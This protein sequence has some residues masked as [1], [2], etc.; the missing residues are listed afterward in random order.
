M[1]STGIY[2]KNLTGERQNMSC[3]VDE[4]EAEG[5]IEF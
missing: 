2:V 1:T 5:L 3:L 4:A